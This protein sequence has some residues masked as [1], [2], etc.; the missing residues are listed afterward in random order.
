[1]TGTTKNEEPLEKNSF[2]DDGNHY[3]APYLNEM[4]LKVLR[5]FFFLSYSKVMLITIAS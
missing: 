4:S 3:F 5:V 1:M 2:K